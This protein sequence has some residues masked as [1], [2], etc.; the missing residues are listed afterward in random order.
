MVF[1]NIYNKN[2]I[3]C[4]H[5]WNREGVIG[6]KNGRHRQTKLIQRIIISYLIIYSSSVPHSL[7]FRVHVN[8]II[9]LLTIT[10]FWTVESS[11]DTAAF[12]FVT[13]GWNTF[14]ACCLQNLAKCNFYSSWKHGR[15]QWPF[16]FLYLPTIFTWFQLEWITYY[17]VFPHD[18]NMLW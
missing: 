2:Q 11:S 3:Q 8:L 1:I 14:A 4:A 13:L 10:E 7:S 17:T 9:T 12:I 15:S 6:N 18:C 5:I 16:S